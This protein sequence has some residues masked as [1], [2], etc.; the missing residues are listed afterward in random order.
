MSNGKIEVANVLSE[1][2][3]HLSSGRAGNKEGEVDTK[4]D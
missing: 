2:A 1:V 4:Q 3:L